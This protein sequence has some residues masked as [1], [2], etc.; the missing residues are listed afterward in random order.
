MP[1]CFVCEEKKE[2]SIMDRWIIYQETNNRQELDVCVSCTDQ[3][4]PLKH[5]PVAWTTRTGQ[6]SI[7]DKKLTIQL[8]FNIDIFDGIYLEINR[9]QPYW[10]YYRICKCCYER[11]IGLFVESDA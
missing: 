11:D 3:I 5:H 8:W 4:G 6:C 1:L 9:A 10:I 7:C 2:T